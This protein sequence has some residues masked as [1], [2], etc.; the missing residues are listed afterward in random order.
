MESLVNREFK[1]LVKKGFCVY[2]MPKTTAIAIHSD[3]FNNL[4]HMISPHNCLPNYFLTT[5]MDKI[6]S[7]VKLE[8]VFQ[9][10]PFPIKGVHPVNLC[11]ESAPEL[12]A[13]KYCIYFPVCFKFQYS[14]IE[15]PPLFL[16]KYKIPQKSDALS[17]KTK[18]INNWAFTLFSE[19]SSWLKILLPHCK[20]HPLELYTI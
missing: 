9:D 14:F 16:L 15:C 13:V 17:T 7:L 3:L 4:G 5:R 12:P 1:I 11:S 10:W 18:T 19:K 6:K 20:V 8:P 2:L